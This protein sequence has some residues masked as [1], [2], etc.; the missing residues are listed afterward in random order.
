MHFRN[1]SSDGTFGIG[2]P[3]SCYTRI[4]EKIHPDQT[5]DKCM[6]RYKPFVPT[7]RRTTVHIY[8]PKLNDEDEKVDDQSECLDVSDNQSQSERE[9]E[10]ESVANEKLS[11]EESSTTSSL[12]LSPRAPST[13]QSLS[14]TSIQT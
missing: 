3:G 14:M 2:H 13:L 12:A 11:E 7:R 8:L 5:E 6:A 1:L 4:P 9:L 10:S